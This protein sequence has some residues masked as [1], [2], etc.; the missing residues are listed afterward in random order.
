V[1]GRGAPGVV[2]VEAGLGANLVASEAN[3]EEGLGSVADVAATGSVIDDASVQLDAGAAVAA[4]SHGAAVAVA[5]EAVRE[6]GLG[7]GAT[8]VPV[9]SHRGSS[10]KFPPRIF[11]FEREHTS[12]DWRRRGQKDLP[13]FDQASFC[14]ASPPIFPLSISDIIHI[15]L[16]APAR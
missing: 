15:C 6:E 16:R 11:V 9:A 1:P 7:V 5:S 4:P 2:A 8:E 10:P 14:P 12:Q 3:R 13:I